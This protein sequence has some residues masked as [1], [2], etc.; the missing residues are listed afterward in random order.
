MFDESPPLFKTWTLNRL[1]WEGEVNTE[2]IKNSDEEEGRMTEGRQL[3]AW[4]LI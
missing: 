3:Q 1:L 2:G 4:G